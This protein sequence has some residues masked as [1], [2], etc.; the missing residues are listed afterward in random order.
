MRRPHWPAMAWVLI[1]WCGL[2][3]DRTLAINQ[4]A[5]HDAVHDCVQSGTSA[6]RC[7]SEGHTDAGFRVLLMIG[8][9]LVGFVVLSLLWALSTKPPA[10]ARRHGIDPPLPRS[11]Q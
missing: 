1:G 4:T 10:P 2:M 6:A 5:Y 11:P 3:L 7:A 8:I 9:G